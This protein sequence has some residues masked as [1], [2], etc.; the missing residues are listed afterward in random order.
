MPV[1]HENPFLAEDVLDEVNLHEAESPWPCLLGEKK[2][3]ARSFSETGR[4][5]LIL[6]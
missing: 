5:T 3:D 6:H 4:L 1:C 2:T